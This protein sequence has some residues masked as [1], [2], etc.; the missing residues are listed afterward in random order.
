V[1]IIDSRLDQVQGAE[2]ILIR[3]TIKARFAA[4]GA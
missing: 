3:F 2:T 4:P 1:E